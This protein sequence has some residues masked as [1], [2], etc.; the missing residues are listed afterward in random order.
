LEILDSYYVD[1]NGLNKEAEPLYGMLPNTV[2]IIIEIQCPLEWGSIQT[3]LGSPEPSTTHTFIV[4][5]GGNTNVFTG[6]AGM[7]MNLKMHHFCHLL[8]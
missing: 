5:M 3:L 1:K 6:T 2:I 4:Q 7:C 8:G